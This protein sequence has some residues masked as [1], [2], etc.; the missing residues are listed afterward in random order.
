MFLCVFRKQFC[1]YLKSRGNM[2]GKIIVNDTI[3]IIN[4]LSVFESP[5][6]IRYDKVA[7]KSNINIVIET[8]KYSHKSS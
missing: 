5:N 1:L 6:I 4:C 8:N 7:P 3:S 2:V